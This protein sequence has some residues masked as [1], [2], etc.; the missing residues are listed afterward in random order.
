MKRFINSFFLAA[1]VSGNVF[2]DEVITEKQ[3][4]EAAKENIQKVVSADELKKND[5]V[6]KVEQVVEKKEPVDAYFRTFGYMLGSNSDLL[7]LRLT[8]EELAQVFEGIEMALNREAMPLSQKEDLE[9]MN[10]FFM[11]REKK[12]ID[13][14][15]ALAEVFLKTKDAEKDIVKSASG[16]RYKITKAG[17]A[18][19][20]NADSTVVIDY[21][22]KTIDGKVFD[23]S[24]QRNEKARFYVGALIPG[25]IEALQ[26]IGNG[27]ELEAYIPSDLGYGDNAVGEIPAGSLLIFTIKMHEIINPKD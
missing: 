5:V 17:D 26:L 18:V 9:K 19:R 14:N 20:A 6:A 16:L 12:F 23:S 2:G 24:F 4:A 27:G 8:K 3:K 7:T 25:F 10:K 15:K 11:E 13:E 22:G 1:F 21:E